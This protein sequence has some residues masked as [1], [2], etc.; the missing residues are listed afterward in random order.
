MKRNKFVMIG[1]NNGIVEETNEKYNLDELL[2]KLNSD[3]SYDE[4][5]KYLLEKYI[6]ACKNDK[7]FDVIAYKDLIVNLLGLKDDFD[8]LTLIK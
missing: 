5:L 4:D 7:L 6:T 3:D 2:E 8:V 1:V